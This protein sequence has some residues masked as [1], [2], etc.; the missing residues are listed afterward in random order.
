MVAT[1]RET[2]TWRAS[3]DLG[4]PAPKASEVLALKEQ[5]QCCWTKRLG[6]QLLQYPLVVRLC[7][8]LE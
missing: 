8:V 1:A 5:H 4:V 3:D 7:G 6:Q 2:V